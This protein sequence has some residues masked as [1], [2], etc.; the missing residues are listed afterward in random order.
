MFEVFQIGS[1]IIHPVYIAVVT[2]FLISYL[3][4][5]DS[6]DKQELYKLWLKSIII[7]FL[8]YKLS[9]LIFDISQISSWIYADGGSEGLLAGIIVYYAYLI[10]KTDR[11]YFVESYMFLAV[12]FIMLYNYFEYQALSQWPY[13]VL[14]AVSL[15][16]LSA[17]YFLSNHFRKILTVFVVTTITQLI[18]R[19]FIYNGE[20][21]IGLSVIEW[22]LLISLAYVIVIAFRGLK[23]EVGDTMKANEP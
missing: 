18:L 9:F 7:L 16:S 4:I 5:W 14:M 1:I 22:W 3:L 15:L 10:Y 11:L 12:S 20:I 23:N 13:L 17:M 2:S 6:E 21:L 19:M 8:V